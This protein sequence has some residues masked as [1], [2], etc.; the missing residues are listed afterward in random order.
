MST[1][2]PTVL[3]LL[4]PYLLPIFMVSGNSHATHTQKLISPL[5]SSLPLSSQGTWPWALLTMPSM[6]LSSAQRMLRSQRLLWSSFGGG[7]T[8]V[9]LSAGHVG[10]AL[11]NPPP[12][13]K[14]FLPRLASWACNLP[15]AQRSAF[16]RTPSLLQCSIV[17]ILKFLILCLNFCFESRVW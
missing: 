10:V 14:A 17:A 6:C 9:K 11:A 2:K 15:S 4:I 1:L 8:L 3:W 16:R 12:I 5:H 13:S 7:P